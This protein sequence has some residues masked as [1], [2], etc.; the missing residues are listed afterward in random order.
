MKS[1]RIMKLGFFLLQLLPKQYMQLMFQM[2][3][4]RP[5]NALTKYLLYHMPVYLYL[6]MFIYSKSVLHVDYDEPTYF[7]MEFFFIHKNGPILT[8]VFFKTALF[9]FKA[10]DHRCAGVYRTFHYAYV[11]VHF[12]LFQK[13][14]SIGKTFLI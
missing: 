5:L 1:R 3:N 9:L 10:H 8:K 2:A 7:F 14:L 12:V 6:L 13:I 11:V 4:Y